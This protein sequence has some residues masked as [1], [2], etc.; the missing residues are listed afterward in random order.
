MG[1]SP[2]ERLLPFIFTGAIAQR[3]SI[4]AV[5]PNGHHQ[6]TITLEGSGRYTAEEIRDM[7]VETTTDIE[8]FCAYMKVKAVPSSVKG[9][10]HSLKLQETVLRAMMLK[11]NAEPVKKA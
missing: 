9:I 6:L 10:T 8:K 4:I 11:A 5:E 7:I 3:F 1:T 2:L